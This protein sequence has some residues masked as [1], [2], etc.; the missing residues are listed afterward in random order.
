VPEPRLVITSEADAPKLPQVGDRV[1]VVAGCAV[2]S[3]GVVREVV[4][5][6]PR[7]SIA[8]VFDEDARVGFL[9]EL[10]ER[11]VY[12]VSTIT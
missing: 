10:Y 4:S 5:D 6:G 11:V 9:F 8:V 12:G 2:G 3:C 1:R 7:P